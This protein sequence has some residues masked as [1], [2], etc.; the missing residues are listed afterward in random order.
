MG[1]E[2]SEKP[3][4]FRRPANGWLSQRTAGARRRTRWLLR[5]SNTP[6][7]A[8]M[9]LT[10]R[11]T[12][13]SLRTS[14]VAISLLVLPPATWRNTSSSRGLNPWAVVDGADVASESTRVRSGPAP[15]PRRR[16]A[17]PPTRALP[18]RRRQRA[19]GHPEQD[20][21]ARRLVRCVDVLPRA[22]RAAQRPQSGLGVVFGE[23][24][25]APPACAASALS[26]SLACVSE[27]AS[28]SPE[29]RRA[30]SRSP[31]ASMIST[32]AG[33]SPARW[34]GFS[35]SY[36]T[37][38]IAAAAAAALPWANR[39][40]A[41]PGCGSKPSRLRRGRPPRRPRTPLAGAGFPGG[42]GRSP[43][44]A[45]S[46]HLGGGAHR[47]AAPLPGRTSRPPGVA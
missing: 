18:R 24:S 43:R 42:R 8:R 10:C 15:T 41:K 31:T 9:L 3:P 25:T 38:P 2:A 26:G 17:R 21:R 4:N 11:S 35:V 46:T 20:A 44:C 14:S 37:R 28:S 40:S 39:R 23:R 6:S 27:S 36:A 19:A 32:Q 12:V 33:S 45:G 5:A 1:P 29:A 22:Q 34:R 16:R 13:L 47:L 30:S 7:L